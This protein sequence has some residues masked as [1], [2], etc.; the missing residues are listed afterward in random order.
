LLPGEQELHE[1]LSTVA[2][3]PF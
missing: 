1:V 3:V 2:A